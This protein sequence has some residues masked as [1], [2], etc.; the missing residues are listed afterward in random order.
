MEYMLLR[1]GSVKVFEHLPIYEDVMR[2]MALYDGIEHYWYTTDFGWCRICFDS[3]KSGDCRIL[4]TTVPEII[5]LA[6]MLE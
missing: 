6:A 2:A 3:N 5:K 4:P 1:D